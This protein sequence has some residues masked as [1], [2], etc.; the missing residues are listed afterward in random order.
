M[1]SN[2][3][4]NKI[5][6]GERIYLR[7]LDKG[8]LKYIKKWG[9]DAEILSLIGEVKPMTQGDVEAFFEKV[10][11][12]KNRDWFTIV[13]KE[14]NRVVGEAGLLRMFKP[15]RTT[16][17]TIIIGE[18]DVWGKGYGTE[19]IHLLMEYAFKQLNFHR[20]SIGVVDFNER[21]IRFWEKAGFKKEG[22]QRDGYF[23]NDKYYDFVMMSILEDEYG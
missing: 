13:L 10:Q 3:N 12:D 7:P 22:A 2:E 8:D 17:M 20:I 1:T 5:L 15:W 21:A 4:D 11:N 9:N 18:K 16:D 14:N 19:T 6:D 23:F